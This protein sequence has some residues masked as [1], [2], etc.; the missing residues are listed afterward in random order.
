MSSSSAAVVAMSEN[1]AEIHG[2]KSLKE[3]RKMMERD[4]ED[5]GA[6]R[7]RFEK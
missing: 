7:S 4:L 3:I 1:V 2:L 6:S 5:D